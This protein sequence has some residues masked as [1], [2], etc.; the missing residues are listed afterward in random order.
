MA[1]YSRERVDERR[2]YL[3]SENAELLWA[4][5]HILI[6]GASKCLEIAEEQQD[7]KDKE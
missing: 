1:H 5:S 4:L 2:D 6:T 3:G 7:S